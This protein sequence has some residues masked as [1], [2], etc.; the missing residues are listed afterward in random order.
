MLASLS[1]QE[2]QEWL[3]K[4]STEQLAALRYNWEFWARPEQL[5]PDG[6]WS[7]W[8]AQAGRGFGKTE[9]GAQWIRKRVNG[10]AKMIALV[11]ETQKD[12]EEVMIP[13]IIKVSPPN[14]APDVRYKPVRLRWPTGAIAYG[15]N[16][17]EPDQLRGPEFDTAWVDELAKYK[18]ARETWDMLQFT[19]RKGN[20]RT[21]VTT[22]PRPIPIIKDIRAMSST[23][24]T[25]GKTM[26]NSDNLAPKF[27]E[28]IVNKYGGTRLGRQELEGEIVDDVPGALWT[29]DML[30]RLRID[31]A[32]EMA[33][34]VIG[35]DPSGTGGDSD[36]GDPV[37][38][39]A[40]GRG[41]DG[42]G[43]LL[44]DFT[45]KLSPD[46]WARRAV[47]AYYTFE[48]DRLVAERN[49]GGAM[50]Q[51]L[52]KTADAAVAYK[53]VTASRGK[54][55]RAEPVAALFEQGRCS[56]V[57]SMPE[58]ED[59]MVLMTTHGFEGEGSPNRVDAAVWA[60]TEVM[61]GHQPPVR[62]DEPVSIPKLSMAIRR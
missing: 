54:V 1:E 28:D 24:I 60:L 13:R 23:V 6:E 29:R 61:L 9:M 7:T 18:K 52:I 53:E 22:T 17:T 16:G 57:G 45:C 19:M 10:G 30:D 42:R 35:V 58:L 31:K 50:V 12:L 34:V 36:D 11:A 51:A 3:A 2:R 39:V 32:P 4:L 15:Y 48:A 41:V 40:A 56:I 27:I 44:G 37:G 14:E 46:A 20:P 49:F 21:L 5:E 8:L 25:G 38:I 43:Y 55:A 62:S 26:D 33:R 59:E 47:T